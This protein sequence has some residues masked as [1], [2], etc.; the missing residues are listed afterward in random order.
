MPEEFQDDL[1]M[2]ALFNYEL[3]IP[4]SLII[5]N[6][7]IPWNFHFLVKLLSFIVYQVPEEFQDG[8]VIYA[9]FLIKNLVY[10]FALLYLMLGFFGISIF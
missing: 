8:I 1:F 2:S 6:V 3:G 5:C 9:Y 7:G 10:L 4:F